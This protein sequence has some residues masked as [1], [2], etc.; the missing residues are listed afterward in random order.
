[1]GRAKQRQKVEG[2]RE[3]KGREQKLE[4]KREWG[5]VR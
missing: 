2:R 3:E 4:G 5:K 1:M